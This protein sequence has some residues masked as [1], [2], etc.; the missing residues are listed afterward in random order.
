RGMYDSN[1]KN[2]PNG[3]VT[4]PK[5]G[6]NLVYTLAQIKVTK[7]F[8]RIAAPTASLSLAFSLTH[9]GEGTKGPIL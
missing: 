4:F 1:G 9:P 3:A 8:Q 5:K 7:D 2:N 6:T